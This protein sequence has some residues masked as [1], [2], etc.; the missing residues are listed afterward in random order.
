MK[1]TVTTLMVASLV[2]NVFPAFNIAAIFSLFPLYL[3]NK[4]SRRETLFDYGPVTARRFLLAGYLYWT[5]S[6]LITG[7]PIGNFFSFEFLRFDGALFIAYIPLLLVIDLELDPQFVRWLIGLFLTGMSLVA[8]LG[9]A[10]FVDA[11]L[12]PLGLSRL[13]ESLQLIHNASLS[14]DIFHGFFRA[15]NAAGA[16]YAMAA[17]LAFA[18]L[19]GRK[20]PSLL[21]WPAF[22]LATTV[23]GLILTQSRT[24]YV[25]FV[26]A[27]LLSFFLRRGSFKRALKYGGPILVPLLACLLIQP[28]V[29]H[30]TEAVSDLDDPN[31]VMRFAY[32]QRA[33]D[34][35]TLSPIFG[36]GFA[37]YNDQLKIYSGI[38]HFIYFATGGS[39]ENDDLHAHNS[40]LHFLAEGGIVGLAL[41][42]GVWI[43]TFR[44][45]GKQ[46]QIFEAGSFG[47][48]LAQGIQA[49]IVLEF[50][51]SFTEHMMGTAVTSLT[52]FTMVCLL[53]NLVGW[54]YRIASLIHGKALPVGGLETW[55][56][57]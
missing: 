44:W 6:Y 14:A 38:P 31:I 10:E 21:S 51:M 28:T 52:I 9:L 43:A 26:A 34:E 30:R 49:C 20:R 8:L 18:L 47:H 7:A 29:T 36:T 37:R 15:H 54:K 12:I 39:V 24:A 56:A 41:M 46:K 5:G 42:L 55:P 17:L 32:Y 25:A 4:E 27:I 23:T 48:C 1:K 16:I 3:V 2:G 19:A 11:T 13:P 57:V 22:W 50:F 45:V 35:F 33:I 53:L 40:Y